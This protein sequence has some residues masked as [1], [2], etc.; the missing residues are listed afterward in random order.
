MTRFLRLMTL[1]VLLAAPWLATSS[2]AADLGA[3][4]QAFRVT[5][6]ARGPAPAFSLTSLDGKP[7]ALADQR[8]H[9]VLLYFW[10]TW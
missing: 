5:P 8:G 6:T 7:V 1:A 2:P 10:A 3:L 4:M 9:A